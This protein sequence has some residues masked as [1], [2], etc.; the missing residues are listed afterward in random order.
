M[1]GFAW[2]RVSSSRLA[3]ICD[4]YSYS[5]ELELSHHRDVA[6]MLI[7]LLTKTLCKP[8]RAKL[9]RAPRNSDPNHAQTCT[10]EL[11]RTTMHGRAPS[12]KMCSNPRSFDFRAPL[13]LDSNVYEHWPM[14][15]PSKRRSCCSQTTHTSIRVVSRLNTVGT[16]RSSSHVFKR[17]SSVYKRWDIPNY[18]LYKDQRSCS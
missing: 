1:L 11:R 12:Y 17:L 16:H 3:M 10:T 18:T 14:Q 15:R 8:P 7:I 2:I 9:M 4:I 6:T 5:L 13:N